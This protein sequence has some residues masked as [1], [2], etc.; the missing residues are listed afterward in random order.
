MTEVDVDLGLDGDSPEAT[1]GDV[2]EEGAETRMTRAERLALMRA[3]GQQ[4][5]RVLQPP[6]PHADEPS[7]EERRR[8]IAVGRWSPPRRPQVVE[9]MVASAD[10]GAGADVDE[11]EAEDEAVDPKAA[12]EEPGRAREDVRPVTVAAKTVRRPK[13]KPA[14]RVAQKKRPKQQKRSR[15]ALRKK[16]QSKPRRKAVSR[17]VA[18]RAMVHKAR[19]PVQPKRVVRVAKKP[20]RTPPKRLAAVRKLVR[21]TR[22][23]SPETRFLATADKMLARVKSWP[24]GQ[25]ADRK[26]TAFRHIVRRFAELTR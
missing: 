9:P 26:I 10:E 14:K 7:P 5:P 8:Q 20:P 25:E 15:T 21:L 6:A 24:L 19:R 2:H 22:P 17:K 23:E 13:Q 18:R 4:R 12:V 3:H 11:G 1:D 16:P